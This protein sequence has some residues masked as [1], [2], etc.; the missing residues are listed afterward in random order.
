MFRLLHT[1]DWHLGR[2]LAGY[3]RSAEFEA[4]FDFLEQTIA[5]KNPDLL[6]IS[7]DV[8]D[9]GSP[10]RPDGNLAKLRSTFTNVATV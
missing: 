4:F 5:A 1:S 8:F 3:D 2:K 7:G 9:T 6:I 10:G